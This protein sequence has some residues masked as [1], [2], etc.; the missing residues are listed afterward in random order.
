MSATLDYNGLVGVLRS[1]AGKVKSGVDLLTQLDSA[2]GDGDHGVAMQTAMKA[3]EQ[4]I[5]GCDTATI[6]AVLN[7][8]AMSVMSIDAG[9]TGP[10]LGS[11]F[12]GM[13]GAVGDVSDMDGAL[14]AD[15]F[16]AG[17]TQLQAITT[18][19][20]GD[21]TMMDALIPAVEAMESAAAGDVPAAVLDKAAAAAAAGAEAT[22]NMRAKFGRARNLGERSLGHQDPGATSMS[23]FLRGMAEGAA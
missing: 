4:G 3:L 6:P 17:L 15:M 11:L 23:M 7:S 18:A 14:L 19:K 9:S 13:A 22:K 16:K 10:L 1:A 5:D 21:K 12:M 8:A 2:T 20:V